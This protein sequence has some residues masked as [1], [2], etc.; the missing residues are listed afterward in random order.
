[1]I[2]YTSR[3]NT[4]LNPIMDDITQR[5]PIEDLLYESD[6]VEDYPFNALS[7]CVFD[8]STS[9]FVSHIINDMLPMNKSL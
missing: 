2:N 8:G 1:M 3:V 6:E 7:I 4:I 5:T 9:P